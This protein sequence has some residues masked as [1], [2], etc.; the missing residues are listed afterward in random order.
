VITIDAKTCSQ[1]TVQMAVQQNTTGDAISVNATRD[2][3]AP[4]QGLSVTACYLAGTLDHGDGGTDPNS[5]CAGPG[6]YCCFPPHSIGDTVAVGHLGDPTMTNVY[7]MGVQSLPDVSSAG[8]HPFSHWR[9]PTWDTTN[10]PSR[11]CSTIVDDTVV[12]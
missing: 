9:T 12:P 6:S 7:V 2:G 11:A 1:T 3:G 5:D 10:L 8:P 4:L